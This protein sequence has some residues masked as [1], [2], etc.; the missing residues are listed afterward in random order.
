MICSK[1]GNKF[2]YNRRTYT[3]GDSIICN[4]ESEYDGLIGK[5]IEI[6]DGADKD[7]DNEDPDIYCCLEQPRSIAKI[8]ELEDKFSNLYGTIMTID[9]I[10]LDVV[11][12]W[13][14]A[15]NVYQ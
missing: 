5:I 4:S 6:R 15:I 10:A 13:P 3:V 2:V 1:L 14:D 7:T 9:D 8:K 11:I 12:L